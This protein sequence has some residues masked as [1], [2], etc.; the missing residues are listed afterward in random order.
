MSTEESMNDKH[1][2]KN[3]QLRKGA[4]TVAELSNRL[5]EV[6]EK[7]PCFAIAATVDAMR[8]L[9]EL[10]RQHS[11]ADEGTID[12]ACSAFLTAL[13]NAATLNSAKLIACNPDE[14]IIDYDSSIMN[15]GAV[16]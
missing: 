6:M 8:A 9:K 3:L 2:Q 15:E 10:L 1:L 12:I 11:N 4:S 14:Q 16:E 7:H 13:T 5:H